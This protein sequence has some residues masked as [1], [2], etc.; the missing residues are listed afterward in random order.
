M[1]SMIILLYMSKHIYILPGIYV[2][3]IHFVI[4][5]YLSYPLT[6]NFTFHTS[7]C[8]VKFL[9]NVHLSL[10]CCT[11]ALSILTMYYNENTPVFDLL[12]INIDYVL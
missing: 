3:M 12:F 5:V 1:I 7:W 10:I 4:S 6:C 11:L 8:I 9:L 2:K